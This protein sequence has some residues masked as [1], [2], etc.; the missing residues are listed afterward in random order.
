[1]KTVEVPGSSGYA[2]LGWMMTDDEP[3]RGLF[4]EHVGASEAEVCDQITRT[5]N[6]MRSYRDETYGEIQ[7]VIEGV[8]CTDE[9]ACA[10]VA[11][12]YGHVPWEKN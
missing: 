11:A 10:I 6:S 5:L 1:M 4:V 7:M 12:L 8:E 2:G 3:R 9:P